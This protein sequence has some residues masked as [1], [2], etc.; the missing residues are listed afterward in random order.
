MADPKDRLRA[1]P[2]SLGNLTAALVT[3]EP[4]VVEKEVVKYKYDPNSITPRGDGSYLY[5]R[6]SLTSTG[7]L[8]PED[9]KRE[10]LEDVSVVIR[11]FQT[12]MQWIIGDLINATQ[13]VYGETYL[14]TAT[15]WG[16]EPKTVQEY[17]YVCRK[18]SIRMENLSFGHHQKVAG[19]EP[20]WQVKWL[21]WAL[22]SGASVTLLGQEIAKWRNSDQ[23]NDIPPTK[24]LKNL[25]ALMVKNWNNLSSLPES[26]KAA[27]R[28]MAE[29]VLHQL[30]R[31]K[32]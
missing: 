28:Q 23:G 24:Q 31:G 14:Q 9:V 29:E 17:A 4:E 30:G 1:N 5:K 16:Y 22:G 27:L 18:L 6:F 3:L 25:T 7:L 21:E 11:D 20:E 12:S 10:E 19:L 2:L 32:Q 13:K 26:D 15:E 8:I